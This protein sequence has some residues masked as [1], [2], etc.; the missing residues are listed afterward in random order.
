MTENISSLA[1]LQMMTDIWKFITSKLWNI[2]NKLFTI[3]A[4]LNPSRP[5]DWKLLD[6]GMFL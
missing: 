4:N 6:K 1:S 5:S 3:F 2:Q